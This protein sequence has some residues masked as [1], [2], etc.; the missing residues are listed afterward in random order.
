MNHNQQLLFWLTVVHYISC[1]VIGCFSLCFSRSHT[2]FDTLL[3]TVNIECWLKNRVHALAVG[4]LS[5]TD[6]G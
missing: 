4:S 2:L 1:M 3:T 5:H 6:R